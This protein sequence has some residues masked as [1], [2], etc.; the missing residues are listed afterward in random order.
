[1]NW[2]E[3]AE[4]VR[5]KRRRLKLSQRELA[6]KAGI[7]RNYLSQIENGTAEP[8]YKIVQG[9]CRELQIPTPGGHIPRQTTAQAYA[10]ALVEA[11]NDGAQPG[12][13]VVVTAYIASYKGHRYLINIRE[14]DS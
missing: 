5:A 14:L 2:T 11:M 7:S 6:D 4:K 12:T 13:Y 8:S 9:I 10:D 3:F 1:M